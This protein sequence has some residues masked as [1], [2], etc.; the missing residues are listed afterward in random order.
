MINTDETSTLELKFDQNGL[1][2]AIAQDEQS[3]EI[4]ML[5]WMNQ[6]AFEKTLETGQAHYWS[7]SRQEL[8]HKGS[9]SGAVQIVKEIKIDCDQDAIILLINQKGGGACHTGRPSCFYRNVMKNG[10]LTFNDDQN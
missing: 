1:I 7:R 9:T 4:L 3:K 5:A 2:A 6:E 8:W 10:S